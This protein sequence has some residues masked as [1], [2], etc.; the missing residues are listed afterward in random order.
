MRIQCELTRVLCKV[1]RAWS[2]CPIYL[3]TY[4]YGNFSKNFS[5]FEF[6]SSVGVF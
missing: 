4:F 2:V 1:I 6:Q 5:G 3:K